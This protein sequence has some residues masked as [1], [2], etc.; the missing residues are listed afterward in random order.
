M[1]SYRRRV[2]ARLQQAL[3]HT[4]IVRAL[5]TSD[6]RQ[7]ERV[8]AVLDARVDRLFALA[9]T[10][11]EEGS[12]K[13]SSKDQADVL[14][15][16]ELI[17]RLCDTY[18]RQFLAEDRVQRE[19]DQRYE[20]PEMGL[21][22]MAEQY[23]EDIYYERMEVVAPV[24]EA[25]IDEAGAELSADELQQL[26][27]ALLQTRVVAL[28]AA[29]T[30]RSEDANYKTRSFRLQQ[31]AEAAP[32]PATTSHTIGELAEQFLQHRQASG[33]W[34]P[35]DAAKGRAARVKRLA[36]WFGADTALSEINPMRCQ[37][38]FE[39]FKERNL[40]PTTQNTELKT[41]NA[42]FNYAVQVEWMTRNPAK[43]LRAKEPP[44][45]EQKHPLDADDLQ[46]VF[47]TALV[48]ATKG[49]K[50]IGKKRG[51]SA[52]KIFMGE[53]L[54]GLLLMLYAGLRPGEVVKLRLDGFKDI[55]DV[56][57]LSA[58]PEEGDTLKTEASKR[59]IPVHAQLVELGL[60][61]YVEELRAAGE[62][63]LFPRAARLKA[64][65]KA[66]TAWFPGFRKAVGVTDKK[67]TLHSLRHTFNQHLAKA[68]VQDSIISDLMG[69]RDQSITRGRYGSG[70]PVPQLAAAIEKLDFSKETHALRSVE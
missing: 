67:K 29:L 45:R 26:L 34:K 37:G 23:T 66:L 54:W 35:G 58:E 4:E 16:Q 25:L 56:L 52:T 31:P 61:K 33:T 47:S 30:E 42:L 2:P 63:F 44:P 48:E 53:R 40:A 49:R 9:A 5:L 15:S 68:G 10:V 50:P 17:E 59:R 27:T 20:D 28:K 19:S 21:V 1:W 3:G 18:T 11:A 62:Q 36:E 6:L 70:T 13:M 38:V 7:A 57:C 69:H 39:F 14:R 22:E 41:L 64:P 24:A 65:E 51:E 60:M 55:D 46:K 32:T 12:A 8:A 43:G